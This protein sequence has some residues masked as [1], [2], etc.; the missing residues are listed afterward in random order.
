MKYFLLSFLILTTLQVFCQDQEFVYY[1][2]KDLNITS[3]E[4]SVFN[5]TGMDDN[6]GLLELKCYKKDDKSLVFIAHFTDSSLSTFQGVFRSYHRNG[7]LESEGYYENGAENGL[8]QK[9]DSLGIKTDSN[10]FEKG[11]SIVTTHFA[12]LPDQTRLKAI[13]YTN[14]HETIVIH[15]NKNGK[16]I[17]EKHQVLDDPDK[18]FIKMEKEAS[19]SAFDSRIATDLNIYK[20]KLKSQ[21]VN[22]TC[23]ARFIV[24]A[25]GKVHNVQILSMAGTLL[26]WIV[27]LELTKGPGWKPAEQMVTK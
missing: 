7:N 25:D 23:T 16:I 10:Y 15:Y 17:D 11:K 18:I 6:K 4:N 5:E 22:G 3:K 13:H 24:D 20:D 1:F 14:G 8:W 12:S 26:A 21:N 19:S 27:K 2:D 9:W